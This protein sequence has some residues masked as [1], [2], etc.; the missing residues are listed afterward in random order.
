MDHFARVDLISSI[1]AFY[2]STQPTD[3]LTLVQILRYIGAHNAC[4]GTVH[5]K[6][7]TC[8]IALAIPSSQALINPW[9]LRILLMTNLAPIHLFPYWPGNETTWLSITHSLYPTATATCGTTQHANW[10][11][12]SEETLS[13][14]INGRFNWHNYSGPCIVCVLQVY[15][16][17][18]WTVDSHF[19][20]FYLH[21]ISRQLR[22][23]MDYTF[24]WYTLICSVWH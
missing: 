9:Q 22:T 11:G 8:H 12:Y 4:I 3:H 10:R 24:L 5:Q 16:P 6:L 1:S 2:S 13:I 17:V 7:T 21:R 18:W 14:Y 19:F 15:L 20:F 23:E